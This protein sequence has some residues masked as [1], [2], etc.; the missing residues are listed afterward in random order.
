MRAVVQR[1]SE[2]RV[3]ISG[4]STGEIGPGLAV[5]V[6]ASKSD[7]AA[8]AAWMADRIWGMRIFG[9]ADGKMNLSLADSGLSQI[10]V[11]S[12]FTLLGDTRKSR[13]PSFTD[14][15]GF[16]LGQELYEEFITQLTRLGAD[17]QTGRFGANMQVELI[18]DGP[19]TLVID[20]P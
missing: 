1:V 9:D 3:L 17:V 6:A 14:A 5:L 18:N 20:S 8:A 10:L 15:A 16:E 2:A 7:T 13:R 4:K 12:Q 19:V 11:V